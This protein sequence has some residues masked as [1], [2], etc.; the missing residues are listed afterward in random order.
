VFEQVL[1]QA[2]NFKKYADW[3]RIEHTKK[4]FNR[5]N[6]VIVSVR[7]ISIANQKR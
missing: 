2:E 5:H 7:M 1:E 3:K 4:D 6:Q